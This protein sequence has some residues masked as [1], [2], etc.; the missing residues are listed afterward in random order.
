MKNQTTP[1]TD[2]F[3][4][5]FVALPGMS[6]KSLKYYVLG[7]FHRKQAVTDLWNTLFFS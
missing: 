6:D 2:W 4:G 1:Q 7:F 5:L 3:A